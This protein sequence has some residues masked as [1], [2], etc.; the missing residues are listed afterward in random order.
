MQTLNFQ[1]QAEYEELENGFLKIKAA[2]VKEGVFVFSSEN[3]IP[4]SEEKKGLK[5]LLPMKEL[6]SKK[7]IKK[8][9]I[10]PLVVG[11][12]EITSKNS[13]LIRGHV[14]TQPEI[15]DEFV[16]C[17]LLITDNNTIE[18]IKTKELHDLSVSFNGKYVNE[19][20]IYE[21]EEYDGVF[22]N[23][24]Y[25]HIA[26][27]PPNEGRLGSDVRVYNSKEEDKNMNEN[28]IKELQ[29]QLNELTEKLNKMVEE[30][31]DLEK[32]KE[33]LVE[34]EKENEE[35]KKQ[36]EELAQKCDPEN[37]AIELENIAKEQEKS[38]EICEACEIKVDNSKLA[39]EKLH[40]ATLS[41]MGLNVE[42][43]DSQSAKLA[44]EVA[45]L[46][47]EKFKKK[48]AT[49][50]KSV[51]INN[52]RDSFAAFDYDTASNDPR[53]KQMMYEQR[54]K[55]YYESLKK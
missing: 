12:Q 40:K 46:I 30:K 50:E 20:G 31:Q 55:Q 49:I 26:I 28:L 29:D 2:P 7:A 32:E 14:L 9:Q 1:R 10:S 43:L 8:L 27:L 47:S 3:I 45:T 51:S 25:R 48:T 42:G 11:H 33:K 37:L 16:E 35:L 19:P 13:E 39:G 21:G 34:T 15:N 6:A 38:K 53:L 52:S 24:S 17:E 22:K 5:I 23:I 44:F 4:E 54:L 41:A 36:N 18:Q